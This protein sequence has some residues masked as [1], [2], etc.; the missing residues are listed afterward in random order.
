MRTTKYIRL[1][2]ILCL[3]SSPLAFPTNSY[4]ISDEERQN[5]QDARERAVRENEKN[6]NKVKWEI[7]KS[8]T[9]IFETKFPKEYKYKIFPLQFNNDTVAFSVEIASSLDGQNKKKREKSILIKALQTFGSE[10]TYE[11]VDDILKKEAEKYKHAAKAIGGKLLTDQDIEHKG[12]KGKKF[13]IS[14]RAGEEKYGLRILI[15]MTNYSKIEQVLSGP[16]HTMHSYRSDDFFNS[17]KLIDGITKKENPLGVG[18][19]SYPSKSNIFTA[20]L[21]PKNS[22]YTPRLPIFSPTKN[23]ELMT[24]EIKDPVIDKKVAYNINSYVDKKKFSQNKVRSIIFSEH[25]SKFVEN[26]GSDNL[27]TKDSVVD[28]V[29]TM[30]TKLI[31]SPTEEYPDVTTVFFE[32]RYKGNMLVIQELLCSKNHADSGFHQT[33]FSLMKFHPE[34]YITIEKEQN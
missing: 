20:V 3:A 32:A 16:A 33:L 29:T 21:P 8:I 22:D 10:L 31:I 25:I 27:I 18:W 12:F 7:H 1:L 19:I 11:D 28:G 2:A 17:I 24:F 23:G 9:K 26:A 6:K 13:Y 15:Y 34:K 4:A 14:Y 30:K 5:I